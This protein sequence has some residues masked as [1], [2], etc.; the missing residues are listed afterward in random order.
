MPS[1]LNYLATPYTHPDREMMRQR[2]ELAC[3]IAG[4]LLQRGELIY[5][6]IAHSHPIAQHSDIGGEWGQWQ[7]LCTA[8]VQRCD[9]LLIAT[10]SGWRSS[11]GIAEEVTIAVRLGKPVFL[12]NPD[13][14]DKTV[15]FLDQTTH[16]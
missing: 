9:T 5:S 15:Y 7:A 3:Q 1:E 14:L 8:M 11:R 4:A 10:M 12:L 16:A 2:Y 6:P 13:T